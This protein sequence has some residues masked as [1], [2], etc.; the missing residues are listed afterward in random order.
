[1]RHKQ[2]VGKAVHQMEKYLADDLN[3]GEDSLRVVWRE[4][5]ELQNKHERQQWGAVRLIESSETLLVSLLSVGKG[6][7]G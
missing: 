2:L 3:K 7:S 1:M 6:N 5:K 4:I